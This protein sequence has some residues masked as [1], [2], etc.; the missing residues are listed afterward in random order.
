MSVTKLNSRSF[1]SCSSMIDDDVR[2][3]SSSKLMLLPS[4]MIAWLI[5]VT[6]EIESVLVLVGSWKLLCP[7]VFSVN[8]FVRLYWTVLQVPYS[9]VVPVH[10]PL[11]QELAAARRAMS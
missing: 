5:V 1:A 3:D 7:L 11:L 9:I 6:V 10:V 8:Y 4:G 2:S